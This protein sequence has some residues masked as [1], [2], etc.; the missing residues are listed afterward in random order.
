MK[1][2]FVRW[3]AARIKYR[4]EKTSTNFL[5]ATGIE[6]YVPLQ[7]DKPSIR[8]LIFARTDSEPVLSLPSEC[9]LSISYLHDASANIKLPLK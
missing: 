9:G 8:S 4:T 5:E 3:Y 6:H 7:D 2:R 1:Q